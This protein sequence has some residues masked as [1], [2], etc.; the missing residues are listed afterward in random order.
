[1]Q[2]EAPAY[3]SPVAGPPAVLTY[4]VISESL[5]DAGRRRPIGLC[6]PEKSQNGENQED[7]EEHFGDTRRTGGDAAESENSSNDGDNEEDHCVIEHDGNLGR[8]Y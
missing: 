6:A 3:Q 1:V 8:I 7:N 5:C 2:N 4:A